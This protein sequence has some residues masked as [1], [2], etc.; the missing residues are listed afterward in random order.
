MLNT[1]NGKK[2]LMMGKIDEFLFYVLSFSFALKTKPDWI[3]LEKKCLQN[4]RKKNNN[5]L[6]QSETETVQSLWL[7]NNQ[8]H[9][10]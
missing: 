2:T 3:G 1:E 9:S 7:Q 5:N 8:K 10:K 4:M 6:K